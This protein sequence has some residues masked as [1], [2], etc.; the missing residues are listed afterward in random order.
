MKKYV[1]I[2][3]EK[4]CTGIDFIVLRF[5]PEKLQLK[6]HC[7]LAELSSRLDEKWQ[8]GVWK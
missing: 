6:W 1:V 4:I 3:L 2:L 5:M 7:Q 8:T